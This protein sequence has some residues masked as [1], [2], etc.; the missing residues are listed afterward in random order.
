MVVAE[1]S[2]YLS[3]LGVWTLGGS[4]WLVFILV[5]SLWQGLLIVSWGWLWAIV[6]LIYTDSAAAIGVFSSHSMPRSS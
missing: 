3:D 1:K 2:A 6:S 4:D 5:A